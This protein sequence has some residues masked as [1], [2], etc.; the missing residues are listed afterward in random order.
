MFD[1]KILKQIDWAT[2]VLVLVLVAIGLISIASIMASPFDGD[3]VA[4]S[5]YLEKLNLNYVQ[6][7]GVNFLVGVAAFL[8]VIVF[9]YSFFKFLIKYAY[10]ANLALLVILFTVEKTRGISG[11]FVFEQLDRAIQPAELCKISIIVFLAKIVSENM[12]HEHGRIRSFKSIVIAL[13]VC[14]VP[15]ILVMLQPDFGTAFVYI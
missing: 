7:Q 4:L 13:L 11:W 10:I 2:I 9:D 6:R 1:R 15:T 14:G 5:D 3:E 8:I 12:E